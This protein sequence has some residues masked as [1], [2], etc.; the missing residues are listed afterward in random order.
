V[1][2][3]F[4]W[5]SL[6]MPVSAQE[7]RGSI[8]GVIKDTSGAVLP[9]VTVE[10]RSPALVG[11]Q[12]TV[13]DA[14]GA[15]RFPSL[16]PGK[17]EVTAAL[18]GFTTSKRESITLEV[19]QILKVDVAMGVGNLQENVQV[20]AESPLIDVKQNA[21][22]ASITK[23]VIDR[24]PIGRDFTSVV[25]SAP[26]AQ[27]ESR[28]GGIQIDGSSGSENRFVVDGQD[29]TS[30]RTGTS[31]KEVRTDFLDQVTVKS[32]GYNAEF[33]A[34]TGG[35]ISAIT[36]SGSNA[37]HG[38]MS[39]YYRTEDFN[40]SVRPSLRLN[41]SD[42]T[43]GEY[44]YTRPDDFYN[45]EPVFDLGGPIFKDRTWFYAG[46]VPQ[47]NKSERTVTFADNGQTNTFESISK[48]FDANWNV[49]TQ[50]SQGLRL[51]VA[52]INERTKGGAPL[53]GIQPDGS[54]N[55]PSRS[56]PDPRR[57]DSFNDLYSGTLDWVVSP[58]LFMNVTAGYLTYGSRGSGA[59][60][61]LRH[62]FTGS[63]QQS[64]SFNFPEIPANLRFPSGYFDFPSSSLTLKD[65]WGRI[66]LNADAS[67]YAH[68]AGQH[69]LKV[70]MQY[71]R[72]T[73]N[74]DTGNRYPTIGLNWNATRA[75]LD[76]RRVRGTYGFY[77]VTQTI[78]LGEINS[79]NL[80]FYFQD[81]WTVH[82]RLTLNLGLR[83]DKE[84]IPSYNPDN[85]GIDFNF[86]DKIAPRVG[87]AW[88]VL[89]NSK[90]KV[91]GS[92]GKYFDI[93][94]LEMPRG[95]FGADRSVTYYYTLDTYDWPAIQCSHPPVGGPGCP[96]TFIE[97]VDFRFPANSNTNRLIDPGLKP[98]QAQEFTT[99][100]DHELT[101]TMS[102]GVRYTHKLLDRTFEDTGVLVPGTGEVFRITNPGEGIGENVLRDFAGCT[103]CPNQPRP[104]RKY[105]GIEV[106]LRKRLRDNWQ[107]ITSYTWSR[108]YGNYSGLASSDENGRTSP[109]V[110]RFFDGQY[111]SFN[112]NGQPVF[113][114]LQTD[115]PHS[116][117]VQGSYD[118]KWGTSV[119][120]YYIL[121][122]GTPLQTQMSEK[123]IPFFPFGRGD[124]GRTPNFT[125]T[126]LLIQQD[127]RLGGRRFNVGLDI[128]NLF[129]QDAA[130]GYNTSPFRDGFNISDQ[131]FFA[132]FDPY[133]LAA[134]TSGIRPNAIFNRA[135][136]F[137]SRRSMRVQARFSF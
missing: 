60:T 96:G 79:D 89:G 5:L 91:Y 27:D 29:T 62:T 103:T 59:G 23:E 99:G 68:F 11:V 84:T 13:S 88:D 125:Q 118:F 81:S 87:A 37:F 15:Y 116:F 80:G 126:D 120:L 34:A 107:M 133:A 115:R 119:G 83:T 105:D 9:G 26:G 67:Y 132:G 135:S 108:L 69:Q 127:V 97:Q 122:S 72:L 57:T 17:Y 30:L 32:S 22:S 40:G 95:L 38:G 35:T 3:I 112:A 44:V 61:Q 64:S 20:T 55:D 53:P 7:T 16:P 12:S 14:T 36:K 109:N 42:Q 51:R 25:R 8:E 85:D 63:N 24:I 65:D 18:Q 56:Y 28:A 92:W 66:G 54:S 41:P 45:A 46:F 121:E 113:G 134:A 71:E 49:V 48:E 82:S 124:L 76:G 90:W 70:G 137:Q 77:T 4:L 129:D 86:G 50:L 73:N 52:G 100:L 47:V 31:N 104:E 2:G 131:A 75:A 94:K 10:A 114:L 130:T 21:A 136:A 98:V 19:G 110:N 78:T 106:R 101:Q 111:Y 93:S 58:K 128:T 1:C 39:F 6:A 123:G 33:R 74:A 102:V 117:K 43:V